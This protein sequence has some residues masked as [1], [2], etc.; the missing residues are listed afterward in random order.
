MSTKD[1]T[2]E[3]AAMAVMSGRMTQGDQG[4][5][6]R[7]GGQGPQKADKDHDRGRRGLL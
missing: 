2:G 5:Q 6:G 1:G 7:Q 4:G 3:R